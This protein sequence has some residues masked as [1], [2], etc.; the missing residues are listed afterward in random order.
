MAV[1]GRSYFAMLEWQF[2]LDVRLE[3]GV[4]VEKR[5]LYQEH[6]QTCVRDVQFEQR[7][8]FVNLPSGELKLKVNSHRRIE[9]HNG[10]FF[11]Y[12]GIVSYGDEL[13]GWRSLA[14]SWLESRTQLETQVNKLLYFCFLF[15][16]AGTNHGR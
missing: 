4:A 11:V 12:Q 16:T 15:T 13:I 3:L 5:R 8:A 14:R 10:F 1:L 6:V 9:L 2:Q 7:I